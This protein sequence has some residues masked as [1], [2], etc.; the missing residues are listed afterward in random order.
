MR[1]DEHGE[2]EV[3]RHGSNA[4][5]KSKIKRRIKIRKKSK[6]KSKIKSR[7]ADFKS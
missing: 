2:E 3:M 1:G 4:R 7:T 5:K 6:S